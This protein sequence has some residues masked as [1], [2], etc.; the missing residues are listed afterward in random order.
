MRMLARLPGDYYLARHYVERIRNGLKHRALRQRFSHLRSEFYREFWEA[1]SSRVGAVTQCVRDDY[2]RIARHGNATLVHR[3][4]VMLDSH[5]TLKI[6]GNKP[7]LYQLMAD[8]GFD[9]VPHALFDLSTIERASAFLATQ[10]QVVVKPANGS[11]AGKGVTMHVANT[12][13]LR[14]AASCAAGYSDQLLVEQQI[15]G[16]SYRLL[17]LDGE[18]LDAVRRDPPVLHGDGK[19]R[20]SELISMENERRLNAR[21][22][23]ALSPL[24][25]DLEC[26]ATLRQQQLVA[27]D[28]PA[29]GR[30]F[31]VKSV[32]NQNTAR[33]NHVVRSQVHPSIIE[34]GVRLVK[35]LGI[36][37]AGLDIIT[38][39]IKRPL[40]DA[41]GFI[42]EV[43]STPGLHHHVLVANPESRLPIG[44]LVLERVLND[45]GSWTAGVI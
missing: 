27:R 34:Q 7:L 44:E 3:A 16:D 15:E 10:R 13:Q 20:I 1:A 14:R 19:H 26:R 9:T 5:L 33:E 42:S 18:F 45:N 8:A 43:N 6:A 32:I 2:L 39:D 29:S 38:Q 11:A 21:P 4:E 35:V 28:R 24:T 36:R 41:G 40:K 12:A 17:F 37:L 23:S 30:A 22:I 25:L 31:T